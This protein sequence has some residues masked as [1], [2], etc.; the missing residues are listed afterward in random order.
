MKGK[1]ILF[2]RYFSVFIFIL[3]Y[4]EEKKWT[5]S[6]MKIQDVINLKNYLYA[7]VSG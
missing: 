3:G 2:C 7:C 4:E 1:K 5:Q 6:D